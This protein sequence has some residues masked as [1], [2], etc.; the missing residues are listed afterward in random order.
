MYI[1]E[2]IVFLL[3]QKGDSELKNVPFNYGYLVYLDLF[4]YKIYLPLWTKN[5]VF[6]LAERDVSHIEI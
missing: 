2:D 6:L 1:G 5:L 4:V 3:S